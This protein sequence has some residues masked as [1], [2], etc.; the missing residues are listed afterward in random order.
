[1]P[2]RLTTHV[3]DAA[4]RLFGFYVK[5]IGVAGVVFYFLTGI[6]SVDRDET[7]VVQQFGRVVER[8]VQPGS[9]YALPWPVSKVTKVRVHEMK[10]IV[11]DDFDISN[12]QKGS[13]GGAYLKLT[14][15][16]PYCI[17]G[18]NNIVNISLLIKYTITDPYNYIFRCGSSEALMKS[19]AASIVMKNLAVL[20]VDEILTHGKKKIENTVKLQLQKEMDTFHSGI[21]L[22]FVE[23][24]KITP[25]PAVQAR[26]D[27]VVNAKVTKK[28]AIHT[29]EAYA[30]SVIPRAR[31]EAN[32]MLQKALS[33]QKQQVL[34]AEGETSR[35]IS[36]LSEF[37]KSRTISKR[38]IYLDFISEV[39]PSLQ[40]VRIINKDANR[41]NRKGNTRY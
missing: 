13:R 34:K 19:M 20:S 41:T 10:T 7:A 40:A 2:D 39:Y 24:K 22:S 1:M 31:S 3:N 38:Q 6:Y 5:W 27:D 17:S 25:P 8:G 28:N 12:W 30:N 18:D 37:K 4:K 21:G 36:R 15:L 32:N 33:Y 9:H 35:F 16:K 11:V 23:L 29:A 14:S 26:F